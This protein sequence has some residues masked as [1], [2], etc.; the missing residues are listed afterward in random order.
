MKPALAPNRSVPVLDPV[1]DGR[2]QLKEGPLE[3]ESV[4]YVMVL[5]EH[6]IATFSY[7]WVNKQNRAGSLFVVFGPGVG[8]QPIVESIDEIE[9][10]SEHNFDDWRVGKVHLKQDLK[11]QT[12]QLHVDGERVGIDLRFDAAHPA[13]AYGFHPEGCPNYAATNRLEQAGRMRGTLRVDGRRIEFDTTGARDHSWGTRDWEAPQHWKWLH[14]QAGPELCVHFWQIQARGRTDL[15]GYVLRDGRM[16]EVDSVHIDFS[17]D[18]Q[19]RQTGIDALVHD[20]AGRTTRVAG[21]FFAHFPLVPGPHTTLNEGALSCEID[22]KA[23]LGWVEFMWPTAYLDYLRS[24][25]N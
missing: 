14:A 24:Q 8:D 4:P 21:S 11:L 12:A 9:M 5:P 10:T 25:K 13:Y 3:R 23:G 1:N 16:A 19:Y 7:T 15:R 22:G 18:A 20:T 17:N 2:H 6:K